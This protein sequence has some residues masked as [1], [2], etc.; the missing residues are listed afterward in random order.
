MHGDVHLAFGL[1]P[2]VVLA[3]AVVVSLYVMR[4]VAASVDVAGLGAE[5]VD[6]RG[7]LLERARLRELE[8]VAVVRVLDH[9]RAPVLQGFGLEFLLRDLARHR[10]GRVVHGVVQP[11]RAFPVHLT[12]AK[13]AEAAVAHVAR[14]VAWPPAHL[15]QHHELPP[16]VEVQSEPLEIVQDEVFAPPGS[17]GDARDVPVLELAREEVVGRSAP[18]IRQRL[19]RELELRECS[20]VAALVRM[21][22]ARLGAIRRADLARRRVPLHAEGD[23][24]RVAGDVVDARPRVVALPGPVVRAVHLDPLSD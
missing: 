10:S 2:G 11:V 3:Q 12:R 21:A 20:R 23:V 4:D 15:A 14:L 8:V 17:H 5:A 13:V 7:G 22:H 1:R 24:V 9:A 19:E 6:L 18:R 16:R